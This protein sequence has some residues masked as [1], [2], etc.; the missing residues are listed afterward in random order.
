MNNVNDFE[1]IKGD[2]KLRFIPHG[3]DGEFQVVKKHETRVFTIEKYFDFEL[4]NW[5][6]AIDLCVSKKE[7]LETVNNAIFS[8]RKDFLNFEHPKIQELKD[9]HILH[10]Q[11]IKEYIDGIEVD[12]KSIEN[13]FEPKQIEHPFSKKENFDLFKYF[14]EWFKPQG[15]KV[16]YTYIFNFFIEHKKENFSQSQFFIF[17]SIYSGLN[18]GVRKHSD[19][20]VDHT[21]T[22]FNLENDFNKTK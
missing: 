13:T 2:F 14:D 15:K 17:A 22:L 18:L 3:N 11:H 10:L 19:N 16:K 8:F 7:K 21:K 5:E 20:S 6:N 9:K 4:R 1:F 12:T